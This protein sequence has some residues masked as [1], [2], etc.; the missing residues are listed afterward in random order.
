MQLI[1]TSGGE[2]GQLGMFGRAGQGR[3]G[4]GYLYAELWRLACG[5][6]RMLV[7]ACT[8]LVL[9]QLILLL[10][11]YVASR[12]IN[13]LQLHGAA[14]LQ[15]A[16][17]WLFTVLLLAIASWTVHGPARLLERNVA[18][19]VRRRLSTALLEHLCALPLSWHEAHHS[20]ETA[21]RVQQSTRAL[22]SF[23]QSQFIYLNSLV[24]LVGPLAAL[25]C[26]DPVVGM[27]CSLGFALITLSVLR[28]DRAMIRLAGEENDAERRYAATLVD[29]LGNAGTVLALR[30]PRGVIALLEKRLLSIFTPLRRS[31]VI[32]ELKWFTVDLSSRA[33]S[34]S[35]VALFV[36]RIAHM[37][38]AGST[39]AALL[40]GSIY[41]VWEYANQSSE[42]IGSIAQHFQSYARQ[43]ADY[44]SADLIR[45][46]PAATPPVKSALAASPAT[47]ARVRA[48]AGSQTQTADWSHLDIHELIFHHGAQR[49]SR[50]ALDRVALTLERGKRYALIGDSGS[51]KSTLLRILAGLYV[52]ERVVMRCDSGPLM[53]S[54]AAVSHL[55]RATATLVPQDA[56][57][58]AGSIA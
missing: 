40:L 57:V 6:R 8:L 23:A 55:L 15:D 44:A 36:W 53:P 46:T 52:S 21:H 39:R 27:A 18:L 2:S 50:P 56:E 22:E 11:P 49:A 20:G 12:A 38:Q 41:M 4:V 25:W 47:R 51:G 43:H 16:G 34:A 30:Q 31:I 32:N 7:A 29:A 9:A 28:F 13:A 5:C 26:I 10:V 48:A 58:F 24:R 1:G 17:R 42:V 35:L 33:L 37:Q 54:P 3:G 45:A 19:R 14:G